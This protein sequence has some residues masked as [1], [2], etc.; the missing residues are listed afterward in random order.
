MK[1]TSLV[2]LLYL[3]TFKLLGQ[4]T[5]CDSLNFFVRT[6]TKEIH[7]SQKSNGKVFRTTTGY[8]NK[9]KHSLVWCNKHI[10]LASDCV[11]TVY[12]DRANGIQMDSAT[13]YFWDNKN[14]LIKTV[15]QEKP[16]E[17]NTTE[18]F[19]SDSL[20]KQL[21]YIIKEIADGSTIINL[22]WYEKNQ[23]KNV[24]ESFYGSNPA[25]GKVESHRTY[26][27]MYYHDNRVKTE[28][29]ESKGK[30]DYVSEFSYVESD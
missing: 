8:F 1:K 16:G 17:I 19:Y 23:L 6:K 15:Q 29:I 12:F 14:R 4:H 20:S 24:F 18:Y 10:A 13:H 2:I 5:F 3:L 30:T 22:F 7:V 9:E 28:T 25:G 26:T 27:Y 11:D 21:K